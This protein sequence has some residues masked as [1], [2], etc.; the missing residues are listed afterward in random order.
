MLP[1]SSSIFASKF[2]NMKLYNL[3]YVILA[4]GIFACGT[5][6]VKPVPT[7]Q[8][9]PNRFEKMNSLTWLEGRW[10]LK[11]HDTLS[12]EIWQRKN[13]STYT[14][15]SMDI[16][17]GKDTLRY[18]EI[19]LEQRGTDM[20]YIPVVKGQNEGK[21]VEFKLTKFEDKNLTFENPEHDFPKKIVYRIS[22]D[23]L[24]PA[25]SGPMQGHDVKMEFPMIRVK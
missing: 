12:T 2:I 9:Q 4:T 8:E 25:I 20:Y 5:K 14:A 24:L 22:G 13:D 19:T 6:Q 10:E 15:I 7:Q 18:E 21:K 17:K 16:S 3:F 23:T 1:T 11:M